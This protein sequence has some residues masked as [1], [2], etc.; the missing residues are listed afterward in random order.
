MVR[1]NAHGFDTTKTRAEV[2][3]TEIKPVRQAPI[4]GEEGSS[5]LWLFPITQRKDYL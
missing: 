5:E 1:M 4:Q 3:S 2:A